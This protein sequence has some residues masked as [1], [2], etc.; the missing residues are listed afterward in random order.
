MNP[1]HATKVADYVVALHALK[2]DDRLRGL[3]PRAGIDFA[4]NDY[5][6]L[7]SAP[8]MKRLSWTRSRPVHRSVPAGRGFCAAIAR[9]TN[10]SKQKL[11]V[12]LRR[13][14]RF[15]LAAV[16]LQISLS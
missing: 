1:I 8:R 16:M 9:S 3:K 11:Q 2:E 10:V 14:Q 4:S 15:S 13:R 6:A 5:L 12:S 7:A